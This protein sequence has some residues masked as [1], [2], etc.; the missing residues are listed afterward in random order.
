MFVYT[1]SPYS[2]LYIK[3]ELYKINQ[4]NTLLII[5]YIILL[6]KFAKYYNIDSLSFNKYFKILNKIS[7]VYNYISY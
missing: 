7:I 5:Y 3:R 2:N 1:M 6:Y 4:R